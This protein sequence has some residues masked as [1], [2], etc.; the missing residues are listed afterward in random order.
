MEVMLGHHR[1]QIIA[2]PGIVFNQT[3]QSHTDLAEQYL[4]LV[5]KYGVIDVLLEIIDVIVLGLYLCLKQRRKGKWEIENV[6]G[7]FPRNI[8]NAIPIICYDT[9]PFLLNFLFTQIVAFC[10][11]VGVGILVDELIQKEHIHTDTKMIANPFPQ[12]WD[13]IF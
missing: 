3:W 13:V 10:I 2:L 12:I 6:F 5:Q 8:H 7:L 1:H 11:F 9:V 4:V